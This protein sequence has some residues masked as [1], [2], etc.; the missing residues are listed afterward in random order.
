MK[1]R[2]PYINRL[3]MAW[4]LLVLT[5]QLGAQSID[6]VVGAIPG[7]GGPGGLRL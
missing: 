7:S 2:S 1:R 4:L 3:V 6:T 5:G